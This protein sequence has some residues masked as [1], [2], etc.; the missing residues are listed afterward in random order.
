MAF[1]GASLSDNHLRRVEG[2]GRA[3]DMWK[4]TMD[5]FE[6]QTLLEK[7]SARRKLYTATMATYESVL[8]F[9]NLAKHLA[10]I[11]TSMNVVMDDS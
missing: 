4:C 8:E 11:S 3:C 9:K 5:V 2:T 7:L 10:H 6:L 1:I